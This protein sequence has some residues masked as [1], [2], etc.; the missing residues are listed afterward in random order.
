MHL[1]N[2]LVISIG[3]PPTN[4]T[5]QY[6]PKYDNTSAYTDSDPNMNTN[7]TTTTTTTNPE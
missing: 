6:I 5:W 1:F 4:F 3:K 7:T 2:I